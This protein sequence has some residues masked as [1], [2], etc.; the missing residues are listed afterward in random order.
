[1]SF[2]VLL[3]AATTVAPLPPICTDRPTKA[4]ATCTVPK[5]HFQVESSVAGWSLTKAVGIRVDVLTL[6]ATTVKYG[7]GDRSDLQV[8]FAPII[9]VRAMAPGARE[10]LSGFGDVTV[11]YKHR[12]T[13]DDARVA[14]GIIPFVKLPTAKRGIG[15]R[16]VEG[17]V[18]LP[19]STA[20]AS[21]TLT[22]GPEA[23]LLADGNGHGYHLA[24]V[25]LVN[26]AVPVVPKLTVAG[27]VWSNLNFDPAGTLKQ[28]SADV[29]LAYAASDRLQLD[30][31]ANAGLTRDTPDVE[32][33]GGLSFR[34]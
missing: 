23:D 29:A 18:A 17:G 19:I 2:A 3:A 5:G 28:A 30:L 15:N 12:L 16:K 33:Y 31:G 14:V 1:V 20:V 25:N 8:G 4:N 7:I 34:F 22:V 13:P 27:E 21:A 6:G 24:V 26:L 11:R 10:T 32:I 9:R